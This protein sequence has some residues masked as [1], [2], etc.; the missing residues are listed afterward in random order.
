MKGQQAMFQ[1]ICHEFALAKTEDEFEEL[2]DTAEGFGDGLKDVSDSIPIVLPR[3][4]TSPPEVEFPEPSD[5]F[6]TGFIEMNKEKFDSYFA[7]I[8][9]HFETLMAN[10]K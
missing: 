10:M 9:A 7:G 5:E 6:G 2:A 1:R 3:G 4:I 8:I